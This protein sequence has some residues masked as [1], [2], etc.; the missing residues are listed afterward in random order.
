MGEDVP[1]AKEEM[2]FSPEMPSDKPT[3][4]SRCCVNQKNDDLQVQAEEALLELTELICQKHGPFRGR[5]KLLWRLL[6][7]TATK[8]IWR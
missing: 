1:S 2:M 3:W 7:W 5:Y 4:V 6:E 8:L